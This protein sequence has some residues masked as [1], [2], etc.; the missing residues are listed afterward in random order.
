MPLQPRERRNPRVKVV[1][2]APR[3]PSRNM[4]VF[5]GVR[6]PRILPASSVAASFSRNIPLEV[7]LCIAYLSKLPVILIP[8]PEKGIF[9]QEQTG[10]PD[11]LNA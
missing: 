5:S 6:G 4:V 9:W 2:P 3:S 11:F 10:M 1:L 8:E 7:I